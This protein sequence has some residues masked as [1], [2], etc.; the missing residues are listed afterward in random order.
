M[1]GDQTNEDK[2]YQNESSDLENGSPNLCLSS[3]CEK[4]LKMR[5]N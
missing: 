5:W 2:K 4:H 3:L 1:H